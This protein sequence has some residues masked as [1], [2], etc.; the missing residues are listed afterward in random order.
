M[1]TSFSGG[2]S[3][4]T[5]LLE[6]GIDKSLYGKHSYF[7]HKRI[8]IVVYGYTSHCLYKISYFVGKS[9]ILWRGH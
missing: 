6:F 3:R 4:S 8:S 5:R 2:R 9:Y 1:A 7:L